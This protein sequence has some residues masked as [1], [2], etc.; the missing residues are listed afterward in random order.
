MVQVSA[1]A[2]K[3]GAYVF[4]CTSIAC[5][6][7]WQQIFMPA[8]SSRGF[9]PPESCVG[10]KT[11]ISALPASGWQ[12][13]WGS[14][15]YYPLREA[16]AHGTRYAL[17]SC[18]MLVPV[19]PIRDADSMQHQQERLESLWSSDQLDSHTCLNA[20]LASVYGIT[21]DLKTLPSIAERADHV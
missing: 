8:S 14:S 6:A 17:R 4:N 15:K 5:S 20:L 3:A 7:L 9:I 19:A 16:A 1:A 11:R 12:S 2:I 18:S 21:D 13:L 10:C